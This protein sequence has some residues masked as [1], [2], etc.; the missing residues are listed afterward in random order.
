MLSHMFIEKIGCQLIF[1]NN[2]K[3]DWISTI[4]YKLG[5]SA[6]RILDAKF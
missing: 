6:I 2:F 4:A 3:R 1:E 5:E